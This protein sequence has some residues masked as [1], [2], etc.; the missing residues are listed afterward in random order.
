MNDDT[1]N[2]QPPEDPV[3]PQ[4]ESAEEY[5][6]AEVKEAEAEELVPEV[7]RMSITDKIIGV[8][9]EPEPVFEN[10]KE[11]G[12]RAGDWLLPIGLFMVVMII[13]TL[14]RFSDPAFLSEIANKQAEA[15]QEKVDSG[16]MTQEQADMALD[17]IE[18]MGGT[19]MM[20]GSAVGILFVMPIIFL[21]MAFIY[22]LFLKFAFK[23]SATF[24]LVFAAIGLV[25]YISI[26]DPLISFILS[27]ITGNVFATFSPTMFMEADLQSTLYRFMSALN[28]ITIWATY[29]LGV[30]FSKIAEIPKTKALALT[31]GLWA[32]YVV[33]NGFT[34][35]LSGGMG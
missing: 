26:L 28:P 29:V 2:N 22:W 23:G 17:Q 13:M 21:A 7:P 9:T 12:P 25:A 19:I 18:G 16:D 4:E 3:N 35:A 10:V 31:F 20:I 1:T 15:L 6:M 14:I 30:G 5:S 34:G 8:Y 24:H 33:V 27:Y 32:V 11:A